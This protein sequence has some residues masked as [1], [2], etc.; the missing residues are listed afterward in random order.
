MPSPRRTVIVVA[1]FAAGAVLLFGVVWWRDLARRSQMPSALVDRLAESA[2]LIEREID[3]ELD[4]WERMA[5]G[6]EEIGRLPPDGTGLVFDARGVL[7]VRGEKLAFY[8][9]VAPPQFQ[10]DERLARARSAEELGRPLDALALY[11]EAASS[12][13]RTVRATATW[14]MAA[15][16]EQLGRH[17]DALVAFGDLTTMVEATVDGTPA[18][19]LGHRGRE[20][21]FRSQGDVVSA[22]R[23]RGLI[24]EALIG[25]RW[26]ME[27]PVFDRFLPAVAPRA[28]PASSLDRS[29]AVATMWPR[30]GGS[31]SGRTV[32][33]GGTA[34]YAAVWRQVEAGRRTVIAPLDALMTRA[35]AAAGPLSV[36]IALEDALKIHLWGPKPSGTDSA[37]HS[38]ERVGLPV[39]LRLWLRER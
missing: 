36:T 9:A 17:A 2:A 11:Q 24:A 16:L 26:M 33:R 38:L 23:E 25:H 19:L 27:K 37:S 22:E 13:G 12:T 30:F 34:G 31:G 15:L 6:P 29:E 14:R 5:N 39:T 4:D 8:P 10:P 7:S 3:A 32:A 18:P 1:T 35:V 28:Y 20:L 21:M